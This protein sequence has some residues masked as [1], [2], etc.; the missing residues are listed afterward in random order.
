M[1][2]LKDLKDLKDVINGDTVTVGAREYEK[3]PDGG[4]VMYAVQVAA[5][6]NYT[7][8]GIEAKK[9]QAQAV[10]VECD[11]LLAELDKLGI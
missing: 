11:V 3:N 4:M 10:V 8:G 2:D 5:I 6:K 1:E 7:R 9:A